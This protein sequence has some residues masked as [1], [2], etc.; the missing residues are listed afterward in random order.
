MCIAIYKPAGKLIDRE[1]LHR[2]YLK[3][4][5]GCGFAYFKSDGELIIM[6]SMKFEEFYED[7]EFHSVVN[8]DRPFL[9]HFRIATHGTVDLYNCHPFKIDDTHVMIHN[10]IIHNIRKCPDKKRS[11]TQMFVDDILKELP[12]SWM[13]N[14][15]IAN[16]IEDYIGASKVVVLA[17][18]DS[19]SIYNEIKGEWSDGIWYSNSGYKE[20]KSCYYSRG[21]DDKDYYGQRYFQKDTPYNYERPKYDARGDRDGSYYG[22]WE[23]NAKTSTH[24]WVEAERE[25]TSATKGAVWAWDTKKGAMGWVIVTDDPDEKIESKTI[26][27]KWIYN[28]ETGMM[29]KFVDGEYAGESHKAS[30]KYR[31][32]QLALVE[33]KQLPLLEDPTEREYETCCS[34]CQVLETDRLFVVDEF[35]EADDC[36]ICS[37]CIEEYIAAGQ[38]MTNPI[39]V[40]DLKSIEKEIQNICQ[41]TTRNQS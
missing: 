32:K 37:R 6:K 25:V 3:N 18:D 21:D 8:H 23:Y 7:Y 27:T 36:F 28:K 17:A 15:G 12:Q 13:L 14:R 40:S 22:R 20:V 4:R 31:Q 24:E 26:V 10:G 30:P 33:Q 41:D 11:D 5:D 19:A 38:D 34:C 35:K 9:I 1:T 29:D 16:L 2:C 39:K